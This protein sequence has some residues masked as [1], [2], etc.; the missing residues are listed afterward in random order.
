MHRAFDRTPGGVRGAPGGWDF[1]TRGPASH[2]PAEV[3]Y[4][5]PGTL[6]GSPAQCEEP[7]LALAPRPKPSGAVTDNAVYVSYA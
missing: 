4:P 2:W 5:R 6:A 3:V 1:I 7:L